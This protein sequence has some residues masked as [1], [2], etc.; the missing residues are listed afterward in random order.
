MIV[1]GLRELLL[2]SGYSPAKALCRMA[3]SELSKS[4][5]KTDLGP[6]SYC[7]RACKVFSVL[8]VP[9]GYQDMNKSSALIA[10][11]VHIPYNE[12]SNTT[13]E[14]GLRFH[15]LKENTTAY[16]NELTQLYYYVSQV[17]LGNKYCSPG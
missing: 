8:Q 5:S 1:P 2:S 13:T 11:M 16:I 10:P 9:V 14:H 6:L 15:I 7:Y 4:A 17:A 12:V 3:W